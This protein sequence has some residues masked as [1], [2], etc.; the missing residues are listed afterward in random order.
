MLQLGLPVQIQEQN[1]LF[2]AWYWPHKP[3]GTVQ[4]LYLPKIKS[5]YKAEWR[6]EPKASYQG[7]QFLGDSSVRLLLWNADYEDLMKDLE[8]LEN[9]YKPTDLN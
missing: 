8:H 4:E 3:I 7:S 6:V 2:A 5:K 1:H 9:N